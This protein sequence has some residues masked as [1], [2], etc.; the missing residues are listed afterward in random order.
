MPS[1][2][3]SEMCIRDRP[4]KLNSFLPDGF[5]LGD[6][7]NQGVEVNQNGQTYVA[8]NWKAN[9]TGSS[10]TSGTINTT[11]TSANTAAGFSIITY[12]GNGSNNQTLGHGLSAAP[13]FIMCKKRS[14]NEHW[15]TYRND[16][17]TAKRM[18]LN[19]QNAE[20]THGSVWPTVATSSLITI[21]TAG[22][23]N[24]NAGTYV[25]WCWHSVE[26]Y[27]KIGRYEGN[28]NANGPFVYTGFRPAWVMFKALT[29][30]LTWGMIDSLRD[31]YNPD[32]VWLNPSTTAA[33][34]AG[35]GAYEFDLLSNG[36]KLRGT[37]S[38][39]NRND[40]TYL[41]IAF[42]EFPF[43]YTNAR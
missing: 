42:A 31:G 37:G 26:G 9:G 23:V 8:W 12:T 40:E 21:G 16:G 24:D 30:A 29:D 14:T 36:F 3:G 33:E 43:K 39:S 34:Y 38:S 32:T 10:N 20:G 2:V 19:L 4:N 7:T 27:S 28:N 11:A 35:T 6:G 25:M 5:T 15:A 1:L 18:Y 22:D 41:Y 17:G 13:E